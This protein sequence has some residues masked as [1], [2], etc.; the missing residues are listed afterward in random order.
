MK[1]KNRFY[2]LRLNLEEEL[3]VAKMNKTLTNTL[4]QIAKK[5]TGDAQVN[6]QSDRRNKKNDEKAHII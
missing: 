5:S 6:R 3:Y 1:H 2:V 4:Q